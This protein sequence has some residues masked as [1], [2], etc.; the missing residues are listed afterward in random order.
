MKI[1]IVVVSFTLVVLSLFTPATNGETFFLDQSS[2]LL[3]YERVIAQRI[4]RDAD[5]LQTEISEAK[6]RVVRQT[7][8]APAPGTGSGGGIINTISNIFKTIVAMPLRFILWILNLTTSATTTFVGILNGLSGTIQN[9]L[10]RI[11]PGNGS[12]GSGGSTTP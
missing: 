8:P 12:G 6:R 11:S 7:A 3:P 4:R 10:D 1:T 2:E 5:S 9:W